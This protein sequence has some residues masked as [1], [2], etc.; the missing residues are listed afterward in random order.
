MDADEDRKI[1]K[2]IHYY[3]SE[4]K[5]KPRDTTNYI[6]RSACYEHLG[7]YPMALK[8]ALKVCE[9]D[10]DHWKGHHQAMKMYL[11]LGNFEEAAKI[12]QQFRT[13]ES[14]ARLFEELDSKKNKRSHN[15]QKAHKIKTSRNSVHSPPTNSSSQPVPSAPARINAAQN[16]SQEERET[17]C[18]HC[19]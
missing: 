3:S 15:H 18:C 19:F 11:K 10:R 4:I 7:N 12:S 5:M 9:I 8:D 17:G 13:D 6:F 2:V 1:E 16:N 14:F